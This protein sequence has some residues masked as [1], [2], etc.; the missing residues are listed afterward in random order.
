VAVVREARQDDPR[1]VAYTVYR[2]GEDVIASDMKR[3]LRSKLPD[4]MVP[5][6]VVPLLSLP[7]TPNGKID[8]AAL[9]DPFAAS[10]RE[11][12]TDEAPASRTEQ[13]LT[14]IWKSVL[15]VQHVERHD[16]FF[17]LGGY[18]LLSLR[19]AKLAE[20]RLGKRLDPRVLFFHSLR[21]V[22]EI[23]EPAPATSRAEGR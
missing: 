8:R 20:K 23:L 4:Y 1:L 6:I 5:T 21:E 12:V 13:I 11:S 18:S 15:K 2:D 17:E 14:D 19:V 16:N 7:L 10:R 9:P 22:A 3:F